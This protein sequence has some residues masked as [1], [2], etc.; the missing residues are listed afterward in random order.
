M[1]ESMIIGTTIFKMEGN[2]YHT[3]SF[4]R[5]GLAATFLV[6]VTNVVSSPNVTVTVEHRNEDDTTFST[7]GTFS[8]T[9]TLVD[10]F[11]E[12]VTDLKEIIRLKFAFDVG[13]AAGAG[14]HFLIPAPAWRPYP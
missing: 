6:E 12:D 9:I 14:I 5:G 1:E 11:N 13:D 4:P 10:L 8:T 7:A 3:P 2:S